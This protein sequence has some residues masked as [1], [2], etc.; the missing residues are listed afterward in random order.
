MPPF[1]GVRPFAFLSLNVVRGAMGGAA[2]RKSAGTASWAFV[3]AN[4]MWET[5]VVASTTLVSAPEISRASCREVVIIA[6]FY[7][8]IQ[9]KIIWVFFCFFLLPPLARHYKL[10]TMWLKLLVLPSYLTSAALPPSLPPPTFLPNTDF[11]GTVPLFRIVGWP[12][13]EATS[14]TKRF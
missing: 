9:G 4:A 7:F 6:P 8:A 10:S 12:I 14:W 13:R 1:A 3:C 5:S 2:A 11:P